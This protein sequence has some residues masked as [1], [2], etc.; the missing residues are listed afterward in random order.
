MKCRGLRYHAVRLSLTFTLWRYLSVLKH[1]L[2]SRLPPVARLLDRGLAWIEREGFAMARTFKPIACGPDGH[3]VEIHSLLCHAHVDMYLWSVFTFQH[4]V[5]VALPVVVH[6]DGTLTESDL[7]LLESR[8][9][10]IR[11]ISRTEADAQASELLKDKPRCLEY[12]SQTPFGPKLFDYNLMHR[13][14]ATIHLDSDVIFLSDASR[15]REIIHAVPHRFHYNS[16]KRNPS[17]NDEALGLSPRFGPCAGDINAGLMYHPRAFATLD[18]LETCV[19]WILDNYRGPLRKD[20]QLVY[21]VMAGR[22]GSDALPGPYR[23][24][25]TEDVGAPLVSQHYHSVSKSHMAYHGIREILRHRPE[26]TEAFI[27]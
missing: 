16:E 27:P 7:R 26:F 10:G 13:G 21:S 9:H 18:E 24:S 6:D 25:L 17:Y 5:G 4:F 23:V 15:L 19:G 20:D 8:V 22:I 14:R 11:I 12:R 2:F 1:R 3:A